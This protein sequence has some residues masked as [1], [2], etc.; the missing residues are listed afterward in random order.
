MMNQMY[1]CEQLN[2]MNRA[3]LMHFIDIVSF[4]VVDTHLYLDTHPTDKEALEY[5]KYYS[6]LCQKAKKL[7][8]EKF[9]PLTIDTADPDCYWD[10]V[11]EPWPWE[12]GM[13]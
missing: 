10:W 4:Q 11:K 5:F 9:A 13:C 1:Q 3:Q 7:Y 12:G 6:E 2:Q 8:S